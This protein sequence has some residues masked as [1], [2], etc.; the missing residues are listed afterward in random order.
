MDKR[1]MRITWNE[2][3]WEKPSG[4]PWKKEDQGKSDVP[5]ENQYGYGHEEWLF[6]PRYRV[7]DYQYG[8]VRG[9]H[10]AKLKKEKID[11]LYLYTKD[12]NS[13]YY[14]IGILKNVDRIIRNEEE[15]SKIMNK[16]NMY[17]SESIDELM[18][19]YAD[20]SRL[21]NK[22]NTPNL[23][24]RWSDAII[25]EEPLP[26]YIDQVK[27]NRYMPYSLTD[28][29][30][31]TLIE[32]SVESP[33]LE[34]IEGKANSTSTYTKSTKKGKREITSLHVEILD[35]LYNLLTSRT[36]P[37]NLSAEKSRV[38][39]KIIDLL[40]RESN[41]RFNFYEIKTRNS[42]LSNIREGL[43]QVLEYALVDKKINPNKLVIIGP[44]ELKPFEIEY[45]ENLKATIS[46]PLEFWQY[47]IENKKFI[48]K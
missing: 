22:P 23:K 31:Y 16:F 20:T 36:S 46:I 34:F 43:G 14:L 39:G 35:E 18:D 19:V 3:N 21:R 26:V 30:E 6:N 25:L 12:P 29:L 9:V 41:N 32:A 1:Q 10:K 5:F 11:E 15:I 13:N 38:S 37:E 33:N 28:E 44:S 24:F 45:L 8:T 48:E 40:E 47:D 42:G 2:N 7:N 27:Y 17:N 4:H